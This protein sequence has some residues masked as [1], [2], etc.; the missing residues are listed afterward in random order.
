MIKEPGR[1]LTKVAFYEKWLGHVKTGLGSM[2]AYERL[3]DWHYK[4]FGHRRYSSYQSFRQ[5]RDR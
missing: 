4:Q 1:Q 5:V 2:Q 3:E